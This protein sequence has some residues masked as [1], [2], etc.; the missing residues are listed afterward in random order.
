MNIY[1]KKNNK[2]MVFLIMVGLVCILCE[3]GNS[4][5]EWIYENLIIVVMLMF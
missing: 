3:K 2:V 1:I 5:Y 4:W